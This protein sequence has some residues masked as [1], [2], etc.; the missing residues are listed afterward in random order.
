[1]TRLSRFRHIAPITALAVLLAGAAQAQQTGQ[2]MDHSAH[3][4]AAQATGAG[5]TMAG[6]VATAEAAPSTQAYMKAAAE[7]HRAMDVP[8]TG[9]ADVD[10]IRGM[11]PHHE[12][13]IAMAKVALE[14][15][16]DPQ[17]RKLAAEVVRAQEAEVE[18]MTDWLAEH[19]D[20]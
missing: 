13:A 19:D 11:I 3:G 16:T 1:M 4:T 18:W 15:G 12:G 20:E 10:F 8:Y 2:Q 9:D 7:M 17:V 5:A 14:Y 6:A